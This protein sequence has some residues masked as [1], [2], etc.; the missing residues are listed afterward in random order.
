[1]EY[2]SGNVASA[3]P[4]GRTRHSRASAPEAA[5]NTRSVERALN[6]LDAFTATERELTLTD[7]S[8]K[9]A[10]NKSTVYRLA[11]LLELRG[12]LSRNPKTRAYALGPAIFRFVGLVL[13][14]GD[15]A[16][17]CLPHMVAL[18]DQT[19]ETIALNIRVGQSRACIAQ[20]ESRHELRMRLDIGKLLPLYCGAGSKVLLAHMEPEEIEEV[21]RETGLAPLGPGS[22]SDPEMLRRELR[23][24]RRDGYAISKEER[25]AGGHTLAAPLYD[26][27]GLVVASLSVYG[28]SV[29]LPDARIEEL[30]PPVV[31]TAASISKALGFLGDSPERRSVRENGKEG[32]R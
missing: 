15:I 18:R 3:D 16:S 2:E 29:R 6:I 11:G 7:L 4:A 17:L 14:Q 19:G 27:N 21:I 9:L 22:I 30:R 31:A 26:R 24:I 13:H 20:I 8:L 25:T 28:P 23:A 1:M 32:S 12:L 10:L 5:G